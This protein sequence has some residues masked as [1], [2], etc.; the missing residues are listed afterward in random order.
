MSRVAEQE[1]LRLEEIAVT[2]HEYRN[3]RIIDTEDAT[4]A[5]ACIA[6]NLLRRL[7]EKLDG[8]PCQAVGSDVR[9]RV[10]ETGSYCYP[11]VTVVCGQP[12]YDP[13]DR[14]TTI[15]NPRVV[16]EVSSPSTEAD[17]RGKKFNDYRRLDSLQE[18]FLIAQDR[19][20]VETFYRQADGMWVI[21]PTLTEVDARVQFRSL[22]VDIPLTDIYA[23]LELP[24]KP[25]SAEQAA[26]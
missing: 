6:A 21:G 23:G 9:V 5:H 4:F 10:K 17:D 22:N 7:G 14:E 3:G 19:L 15:A 8:S 26:S 11:D 2:K 13:P 12:I 1:Y 25:F 18:Y 24:P 20:S 16:I